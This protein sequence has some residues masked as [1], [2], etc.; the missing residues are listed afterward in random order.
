MRQIRFP[1]GRR[2]PALG[3]G[4][5]HMGM[6]STRR[7]R[8]ADALRHG[9]DLGMTLIDTAEMYHDAELVVADA[10]KDRRDQAFVVSKVLP[11]NASLRSTISACEKSLKRLSMDCIS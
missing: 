4:T 3:Q 5:W 9:M 11:G 1:D 8:E 2:V 6:D 7:R 10:L